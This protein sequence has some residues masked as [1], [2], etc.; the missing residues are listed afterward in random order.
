MYLQKTACIN[1]IFTRKIAN[2]THVKLFFC[3]LWARVKVIGVISRMKNLL[4][5]VFCVLVFRSTWCILVDF[6]FSISKCYLSI[7]KKDLKLRFFH[8]I[9][10]IHTSLSINRQIFFEFKIWSINIHVDLKFPRPS[11]PPPP[12]PNNRLNSTEILQLIT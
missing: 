1:A 4:T 8:F 9:S 12:S 3:S 10:F 2:E 6:F 5:I 11:S 7:K